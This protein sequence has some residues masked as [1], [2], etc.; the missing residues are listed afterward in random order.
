MLP[1][2]ASSWPLGEVSLTPSSHWH[3]RRPPK[4]KKRGG[5]ASG[6]EKKR[7][8]RLR[9][10]TMLWYKR[11]PPPLPLPH[12]TGPFNFYLLKAKYKKMLVDFFVGGGEKIKDSYPLLTL[13]PHCSSL[14]LKQKEGDDW[15]GGIMALT[16]WRPK[17]AS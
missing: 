2:C 5:G 6:N 14:A 15:L 12:I 13:I 10:R 16:T 4:K 11:L 17:R 3:R 7:E 9:N 8:V 1:T